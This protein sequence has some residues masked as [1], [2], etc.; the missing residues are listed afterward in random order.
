MVENKSI[1]PIFD[2]GHSVKIT[3]KAPE[4]YRDMEYGDICGIRII[5]TEKTANQFNEPIGTILYMI[6]SKDGVTLEIPEKFLTL[7]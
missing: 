7:L 4:K 5:E 2:W 6:E 3:N 1:I